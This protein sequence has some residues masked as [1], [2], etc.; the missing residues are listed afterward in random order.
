MGALDIL[1]ERSVGNVILNL[2]QITVFLIKIQ[3]L[4]NESSRY[5]GD[6]IFR[7]CFLFYILFG[8]L[9]DLERKKVLF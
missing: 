4:R 3:L 6:E 9:L 5:W 7:R 1:F 2:E 8:V